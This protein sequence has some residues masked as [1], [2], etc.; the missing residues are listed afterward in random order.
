[1]TAIINNFSYPVILLDNRDADTSYANHLKRGSSG[2][3][4]LAYPYG[5]PV[6]APADGTFQYFDGNGRIGKGSGGNIGRLRLADGSYIEFM[7][8]SSGSANRKVKTGDLLGRSGGSGFGNLRHYAPHLHVHI[9]I[10]GV[11]R[12]LFHYFTA[13]STAAGGSATIIPGATKKEVKMKLAWTTDGTGWLIT[14]QGWTG[15]PSPQV[16]SL[17]H[18]VINSDQSKSPFTN[19][20]APERFNR[21][22]VDMMNGQQR[23]I[24][25]SAQTGTTIDP[26]K[27]ASAISDALGKT[28]TA[29]LPES[30]ME[31]LNDI[32]QGVEDISLTPEDFNIQAAVD[33]EAL[34]AAFAVAVPRVAAAIVK[35]QGAAM[36]S[37]TVPN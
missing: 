29:T 33:P 11:R 27:L 5:S 8:L 17:F 13:S 25:I 3:V 35:A 1:M 19:G 16:Y 26:V 10:G 32:E 37:V 6:Y 24:A 23:L 34:A 20:A 9:Y 21:A 28:I 18:R 2:G 15:L 22:E 14:E 30:L 7:H 4:D 36:A 12:N 31:K